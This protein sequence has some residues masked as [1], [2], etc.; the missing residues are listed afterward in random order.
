MT[1]DEKSAECI[2]GF[3]KLPHF[4]SRG[5]DALYQELKKE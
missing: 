4:S 2:Q 1:I 5:V 3:L